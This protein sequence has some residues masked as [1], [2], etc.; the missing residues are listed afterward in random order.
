MKIKA[1]IKAFTYTSISFEA[2]I[3][4]IIPVNIIALKK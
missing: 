3:E 4:I 2:Y 1:F